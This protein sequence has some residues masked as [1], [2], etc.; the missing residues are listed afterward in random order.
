M[1]GPIHPTPIGDLRLTIL[2]LLL[3]GKRKG[4]TEL[5]HLAVSVLEYLKDAER[6]QHV[7]AN[8]V[9]WNN[10]E[11]RNEVDF[12]NW[13]D[14]EIENERE[15]LVRTRKGREDGVSRGGGAGGAPDPVI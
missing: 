5:T 15:R 13:I 14:K 1:S 9:Q 10:Y 2:E 8:T 4:D 6:W 11:P 3:E 7:A 12:K